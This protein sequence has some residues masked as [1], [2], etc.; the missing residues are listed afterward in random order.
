[1][2]TICHDSAGG[3]KN[4]SSLNLVCDKIKVHSNSRLHGHQAN[5]N[6]HSRLRTF[7]NRAE[8]RK[9]D[10]IDWSLYNFGSS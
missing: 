6:A 7:A 8:S 1:M 5:N 3:D 9:S 4:D 10:L 2:G